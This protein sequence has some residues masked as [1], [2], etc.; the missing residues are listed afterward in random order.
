LIIGVVFLLLLL[1]YFCASEDTIGQSKGLELARVHIQAHY[2]SR[3]LLRAD[4]SS[5]DLSSLTSCITNFK[6][7]TTLGY[8]LW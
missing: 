5:H 1:F 6:T 4:H 3:F 2:S 7:I 8:R